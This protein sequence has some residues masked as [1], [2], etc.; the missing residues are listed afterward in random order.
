MKDKNY[1]KESYTI[2][3]M[4]L[5]IGIAF[6]IIGFSPV[7]KKL[8]ITSFIV[9]GFS[10]LFGFYKF[11]VTRKFQK[12]LPTPSVNN[13]GTK[14]SLLTDELGGQSGF[15]MNGKCVPLSEY[16]LSLLSDPLIVTK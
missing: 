4:F 5:A 8:K 12:S 10:L 7:N 14:C 16:T 13:N 6:L 11:Y 2:A 15:V 3:T 1:I 9:G